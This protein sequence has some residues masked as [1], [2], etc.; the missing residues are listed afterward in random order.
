MQIH[1]LVRRQLN[2]LRQLFTVASIIALVAVLTKLCAAL[3]KCKGLRRLGHVALGAV[4]V[5]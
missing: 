5:K 2:A 3:T 4:P 1:V